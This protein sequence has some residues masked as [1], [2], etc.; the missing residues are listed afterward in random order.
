MISYFYI[1]N[2]F[3][4]LTSALFQSLKIAA[5]LLV[6]M[7]YFYAPLHQSFTYGFHKLAHAISQTDG[8]HEHVAITKNKVHKVVHDH[9]THH[10]HHHAHTSHKHEFLSFLSAIF[11][12]DTGDDDQLLIHKELD[13]HFVKTIAYKPAFLV[14]KPFQEIYFL[15]KNYSFK[16]LPSIP[17]P[18]YYVS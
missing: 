9:H 11:S 10:G 15:V 3:L 16:N 8:S 7:L 4:K 18:R 14:L 6:A 1:N 17:P 13:K 5:I 12:Q 2:Y